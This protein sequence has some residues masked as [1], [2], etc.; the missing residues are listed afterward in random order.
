[1]GKKPTSKAIAIILVVF[2]AFFSFA[3]STAA[4]GETCSHLICF[5]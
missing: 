5:S 1:M 3:K 4:C 2:R